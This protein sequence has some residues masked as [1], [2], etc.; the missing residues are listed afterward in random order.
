M[1]KCLISEGIY[2]IINQILA[3]HNANQDVTIDKLVM[4]THKY[5]TYPEMEKI[6]KA[7]ETKGFVELVYDKRLKLSIVP[8]D[9]LY[10]LQKLVTLSD[11]L[12]KSDP[13][14]YEVAPATLRK[15]LQYLEVSK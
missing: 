11:L 6:V 3:L 2:S 5:C 14:Y 7:L 8:T 12:I 15:I 4:K 1:S 10:M 9:S 13:R